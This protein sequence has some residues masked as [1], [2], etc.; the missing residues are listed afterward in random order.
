MSTAPLPPILGRGDEA[1]SPAL[2]DRPQ[3]GSVTSLLILSLFIFLMTNNGGNDD[4]TVRNQY[5]DNLSSLEWQLSNYSAWLN[6]SDTAKF[7]M[8]RKAHL[9]YPRLSPVKLGPFHEQ[10]TRPPGEYRIISEAV[11][12]R[13]VLDP[14]AHSYYSNITGFVRGSVAFRNF[15]SELVPAT[16]WN[17]TEVAQKFGRWNWSAT[18]KVAM[19]LLSRPV[20][21]DEK[22]KEEFKDVAMLHV[23]VY[24]F[25]S[26]WI[27]CVDDVLGSHRAR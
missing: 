21:V 3:R 20:D 13:G 24:N 16:E 15:S 12:R 10:P 25:E 5:K 9:A 11:P 26:L 27:A 8:V 7:T 18:N 17:E 23:S 1:G 2:A 6:G 19:S 14:L 22:E 4:P